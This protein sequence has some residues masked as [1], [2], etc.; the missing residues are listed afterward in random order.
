[1]LD[2][3]YDPLINGVVNGM[4]LF[5]IGHEYGHVILKHEPIRR[6]SLNAI[7]G[8]EDVANLSFPIAERSW[9]QELEA[10]LV[11]FKLM[12]TT[13]MSQKDP[14]GLYGT[15]GALFFIQLQGILDQADYSIKH[16]RRYVVTQADRDQV[17]AFLKDVTTTPSNSGNKST[18][19]KVTHTAP[20]SNASEKSLIKNKTSNTAKENIFSTHPPDWLRELFLEK[21]TISFLENAK[22]TK[23][24]KNLARFIPLLLQNTQILWEESSDDFTKMHADNVK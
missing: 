24:Q 16:G 13:L 11:G 18:N 1:M 14:L 22:V 21:E 19:P 12:S 7:Q 9:Q 4:E 6:G 20:A 8:G 17:V 2:Q 23:E 10:D 5:V 3:F 15:C